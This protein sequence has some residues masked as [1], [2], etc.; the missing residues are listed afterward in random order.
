MSEQQT[1]VAAAPAEAPAP[2]PAPP[3]SKP[4]KTASPVAR[5]RRNRIIGTIVFLLITAGI[6]FGIWYF[7]FQEKI[8]RA[9][10]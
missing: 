4:K 9:H 6:G 7:L 3:P 2:Q 1:P 8:G 10:V 5:K